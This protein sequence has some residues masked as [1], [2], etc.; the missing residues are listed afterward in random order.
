M[1]AKKEQ[2]QVRDDGGRI[3]TILAFSH[4]GAARLFAEK[5]DPPGHRVVVD[6]KRRGDSSDTWQSFSLT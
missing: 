5:F 3:R 1:G 4:R 2:Y 6:V